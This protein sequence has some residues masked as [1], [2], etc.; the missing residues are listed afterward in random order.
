MFD[1]VFFLDLQEFTLTSQ[2]FGLFTDPIV[3]AGIFTIIV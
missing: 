3:T 2:R 1:D